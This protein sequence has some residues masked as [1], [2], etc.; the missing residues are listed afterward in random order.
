MMDLN[1]RRIIDFLS[2]NGIS[3]IKDSSNTDTR[4]MRNR[5]RHRLIPML[6]N[7]YNPDISRSL[8]RLADILRAEE[9][10]LEPIVRE[11]FGRCLLAEGPDRVVLSVPEL[12]KITAAPRRRVVRTA[13]LQVKGNLRR[14]SLAHVD[15]LALEILDGGSGTVRTAHLPDRIRATRTGSELCIVREKT[16]L[17][18]TNPAPPAP[19]F[20]YHVT[21]PMDLW[22]EEIARRLRFSVISAAD[23]GD[24]AKAAPDTAFFDMAEIRFPLVVRNARDG[25]RFTPLGL[26]GTQKLKAFFINNKIPAGAR[27]RCPILLSGDDI[28]WVAGHR[29]ADAAKVTASSKNLLRVQLLLA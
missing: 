27:R 8:N 3:Y 16:P 22:V 19:V 2:G 13:I 14:I 5:I 18:Q 10:W 11:L 15:R 12:R 21:G 7:D 24:W 9:A 17:R 23:A 29:T 1:R 28:I 6:Q 4:Y 20:H 26:R 25:D